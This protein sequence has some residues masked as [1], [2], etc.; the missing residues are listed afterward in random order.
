MAFHFQKGKTPID[1]AAVYHA[2]FVILVDFIGVDSTDAVANSLSSVEEIKA[3]QDMLLTG[4][5]KSI[6]DSGTGLKEGLL[7]SQVAEEQWQ[8]VAVTT[9][10][11]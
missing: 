10:A 11:T 1:L 5:V 6:A 8:G 2:R 7:M 4:D 9:D 3:F